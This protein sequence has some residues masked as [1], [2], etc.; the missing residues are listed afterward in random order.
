MCIRGAHTGIIVGSTPSLG[1]MWQ[2][3]LLNSVEQQL[4]KQ[5]MFLSLRHVVFIVETLSP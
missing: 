5:K 4:F 2:I 3:I 1:H